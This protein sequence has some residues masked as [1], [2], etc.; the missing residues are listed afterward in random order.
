MLHHALPNQ[1]VGVVHR[2]RR[3]LPRPERVQARAGVERSASDRR[4][5]FDVIGHDRLS[6]IWQADEG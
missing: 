3:H 5:R 1:V 4:N 6:S 2:H